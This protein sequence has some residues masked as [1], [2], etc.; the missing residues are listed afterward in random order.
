MIWKI[1][2]N[3]LSLN[4]TLVM[5]IL[6]VTPDSFSD[7]GKY[8]DKEKAVEHADKLAKEGAD[9]VDIGAESTRPGSLGVSAEDEIKKL[10]P[11]VEAVAQ[12]ID[13]PISIDTAKPEVA[14]A[15]LKAGANIIND[16][17]GL[18][19]G[20][21]EMARVVREFDA[22]IVIMHSRGTPDSMQTLTRYAD[23]IPDVLRELKESIQIALDAEVKAEQIVIDPGIGLPKTTEQN[24]E[25]IRRLDS[26]KELGF[27]VLL[28][29]SRKKFIGELTG[30][31]MP[32]NRDFGTAAISVLIKG[33]DAQILRIHNVSA[34]RDALRIKEAIF[35]N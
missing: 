3:E 34:T 15:C 31:D 23:L 10:L 25:I 35:E 1:R 30:Q 27:P 13:I 22:G 4:K 8:L 18:R 20:G 33:S 17:S 7:G 6:N 11:I 9:I 29:A 14:R 5:G 32:M 2:G 24:L 26:F 12:K 19:Y 21:M 28:G 16:V